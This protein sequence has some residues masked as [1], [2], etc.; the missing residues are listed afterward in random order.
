[1]SVALENARL[2]AE[3]QRLFKAEQERVAE[4]QIINSIQQGLAAELDFQAIVDLVGDKL[5]EVLQA[6]D[7]GI[8]WFDHRTATTHFLYVFE[9]GVRL[10]IPSKTFATDHGYNR[11]IEARQ[12]LSWG[13]AAEGTAICPAIPGTDTS[14]SGFM[15]PI[16]SGDRM[17]GSIQVE[18]YE[19]EHAYGESE[20]RLLTTIAASLGTALENARL[21]ARRSACSRRPSSGSPSWRSS[22]ASSRAWP[23]SWTSRPS[24]TWSAT[25][26]ARCSRRRTSG[27]TLVRSEHRP[28]QHPLCRTSTASG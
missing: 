23:P 21:F 16:V 2:F 26:C 13:T 19:R 17:I 7:I 20:L 1:M 25:S 15:V 11:L 8:K 28:T 12:P 10:T 24:S 14:L 3:T 4:L 6:A 27:I 9:H 22:T 5:R 18:N